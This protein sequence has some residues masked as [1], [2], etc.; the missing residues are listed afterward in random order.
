MDKN[1]IVY[2]RQIPKKKK[3]PIKEHFAT[4]LCLTIFYGIKIAIQKK[5][6]NKILNTHMHINTHTMAKERNKNNTNDKRIMM[7]E[8]EREENAP[9][10]IHFGKESRR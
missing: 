6:N 1:Y 7:R 2:Y 8:R 5:V 10:H 9:L 3:N 4:K